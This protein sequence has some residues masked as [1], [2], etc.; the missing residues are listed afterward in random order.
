MQYGEDYHY[1]PVTS[2]LSKVGQIVLPDIYCYTIQVVNIVFIGD[3][4]KDEGWV[5][6]DAGIPKSSQA[7]IDEA[8]RRFGKNT[9]PKVILLT[10]GHFDHVGAIIE[11]VKHWEVPVYAH[12]LEMPHLTGKKHY[13]EPDATVGGGLVASMSPTFPYKSLILGD[14]VQALPEDGSVPYLPDWNWVHTPGHSLGHVSFFREKDRTLIVG[15]AFVTVKQESLYKVFT[16]EKEFSGPPKYFTTDWSAA[17]KSVQILNQLKPQ[18]AIPGQGVPV[19]GEELTTELAK[20]ATLFDT[21]GMPTQGR[22]L[23]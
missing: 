13:P 6:V 5:L 19:G 3:S 21:L 20:L 7:I 8:E 16:Q 9:K 10:H 17:W 11:L 2:I 22:Y 4:S 14:I 12:F 15:D 18:V 1:I 23:H